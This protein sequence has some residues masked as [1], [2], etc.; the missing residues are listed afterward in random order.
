MIRFQLLV[1]EFLQCADMRRIRD[2]DPE[3][4]W[5]ISPN[6]SV[7]ERKGGHSGRESG[8]ESIKPLVVFGCTVGPYVS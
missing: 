3:E 6:D 2:D 5:F 7:P 4:D 1:D 8:D